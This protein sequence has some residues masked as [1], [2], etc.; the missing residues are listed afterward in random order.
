MS[1]RSRNRSVT[2]TRVETKLPEIE[3]EEH[4]LYGPPPIRGASRRQRIPSESA[5][6]STQYFFFGTLMDRDV[7][8]RVLERSVDPA[9][10]APARLPGYRRMR[11]LRDSFPVLVEDPAAAVDGLVFTSAS[12]DEDAR[13]L[14][15]EDYDYDMAPCRPVLPDGR[16]V[17]AT[18]CGA[19]EGMQASDEPWELRPWADRHKPGFLEL[20][21]IYMACYGRMTPD[22]AE[23]VWVE[24]RERLRAEGVL[25]RAPELAPVTEG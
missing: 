19:E 1:L 14:F 5:T 8:E 13:I 16:V 22:E 10:L 23:S 3:P 7:L 17:E 6:M 21:R 9:A 20:S 18:F 15:F 24:T 25:L 11:I 12:A 2:P 4:S